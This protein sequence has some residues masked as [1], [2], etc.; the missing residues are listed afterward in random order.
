MRQIKKKK[1]E[2]SHFLNIVFIF[3]LLLILL[4]TVSVISKRYLFRFFSF[5]QTNNSILTHGPLVGAVTDN[6]AT[7]W[8]RVDAP[9]TSSISIRYSTD[10]D[11]LL[12]S[13]T[14]LPQ[15]VEQKSMTP[16]YYANA[17]DGSNDWDKTWKVQLSNLNSLVQYYYAVYKDNSLLQSKVYTFKTFAMPGQ[18]VNFSFGVLTDFATNGSTQ[19]PSKQ[20]SDTFRNLFN[21]NPSFVVIGGDFWHNDAGNESSTPQQFV[22]TTRNY[23]K[24]MYLLNS[25]LG[26]FN[27]LITLIYPNFP[28]IH[29][30][31]DHDIGK[32]AADKNY[33]YKDEAL[34]VLKEYFPTYEMSQLG[35]WQKFSYGQADFFVLDGRSQRDP[36]KDVDGPDNS[37]LD[38]DNLGIKGQYYWLTQGLKN[39][40]A[41]WKFILSPLV[42]NPTHNKRDAWKGFLN[43]R[44]KLVKF[45]KN[46]NIKGVVVISGDSHAGGIDD[47]TNSDFP[48]LFVPMPNSGQCL[49]TRG[50][51][52]NWSHGVYQNLTKN[53]EF[54]PPCPGFGMVR[55]L[56]NPDRIILKII[57]DKNE[58][59]LRLRYFLNTSEANTSNLPADE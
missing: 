59:K 34:A 25:P 40:T 13:G 38:G 52:G 37:M 26:N 31:D 2:E 44:S 6:S 28:L 19:A 55:V 3:S 17:K 14:N 27:D 32:N 16:V 33:E 47:G 50:T 51:I 22:N 15:G 4:L 21:R 53:D 46:N 18:S 10:K 56:T 48:E 41:K 54:D 30:W 45:I 35:D 11:R 20:N 8:A 29:Y 42:F 58:L 36:T 12:G 43:E 39:S 49:T 23:F 5:A 1:R 57:N 9:N 7:I 24:K